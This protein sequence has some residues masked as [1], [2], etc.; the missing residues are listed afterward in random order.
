M[1]EEELLSFL[2][3]KYEGMTHNQIIV[4]VREELTSLGQ[5]MQL[6]PNFNKLARKTK[7]RSELLLLAD[8][9]IQ[10]ARKTNKKVPLEEK[11]TSIST[12]TV[13]DT[14]TTTTTPTTTST[15]KEEVYIKED[16]TLIELISLSFHEL[17]FEETAKIQMFVKFSKYYKVLEVLDTNKVF[18]IT[19]ATTLCRE[20]N[21]DIS[22]PTM[23]NLLDDL[24]MYGFINRKKFT[25]GK[26][27]PA[28]VYN[29]FNCPEELYERYVDKFIAEI[30]T[31]YKPQ[32][33]VKDTLTLRNS[34][35]T[36]SASKGNRSKK[37]DS[38]HDEIYLQLIEKDYRNKI[39]ERNLKNKPAYEGYYKKLL[40][41]GKLPEELILE[42][43][44][45]E[46]E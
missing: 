24:Y 38:E 34:L 40:R 10:K 15:I 16:F 21:I 44:R 32:Y 18:T 28:F 39:L 33:N 8:K 36:N 4:N 11:Q 2:N 14:T 37:N 23:S 17:F 1:L 41:E 43:Y 31:V 5:N 6:Y 27:L 45:E 13:G 22:L 9:T 42:E 7:D 25:T 30:P 29:T 26:L 3:E 46:E 20:E 12:A 35:V 19:K